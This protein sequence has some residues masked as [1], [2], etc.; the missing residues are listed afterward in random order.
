MRKIIKTIEHVNPPFIE[1]EIV[2][3]VDIEENEVRGIRTNKLENL[4]TDDE[5]NDDTDEEEEELPAN[6]NIEEI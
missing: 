2:D 6:K 1:Y 4:N 5:I 3:D